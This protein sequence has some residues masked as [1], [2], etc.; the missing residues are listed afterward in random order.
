MKTSGFQQLSPEAVRCILQSSKLTADE[1]DILTAVKEWAVV[2]AS[3]TCQPV[4][5]VIQSVVR[6]VRLALLGPEDLEKLEG[7]IRAELWADKCKLQPILKT[8]K[9]LHWFF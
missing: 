9:N 2:N 7:T 1:T 6:H 8:K 3:V 5:K 4:Q